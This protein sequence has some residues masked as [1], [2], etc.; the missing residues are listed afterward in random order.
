MAIYR[1]DQ[2]Q[3]TFAA[4]GVAGGAPERLDAATVYTGTALNGAVSKGDRTITV[5]AITNIN[6]TTKQ[7]LIIGGD[8]ATGAINTSELRRVVGITG[9]IVTLENPLSFDH[10]D[11][12]VVEAIDH[13]S[14]NDPDSKFEARTVSASNSETSAYITWIPGIYD[15]VDAPDP[16]EAMEPRYMLGQNTVRNPYQI[17]K[18]Q[19]TLTG[20]VAGITLINGWPLRFALG[21]VQTLQSTGRTKISSNANA[22]LC[23][24]DI[25]K[26][27]VMVKLTATTSATSNGVL[28]AGNYLIFGNAT[29]ATST[30]TCEVRKIVTGT[31]TISAG[32]SAYVR[33]NY[34]VHFAHTAEPAYYATT[35]TSEDA[36]TVFTHHIFDSVE[37]PSVSWNINVKD[38]NGANSFQRRYTGGK[39]GSMTLTAEEGGLLT[40]DWDTATFMNF[41][42][43]QQRS[44]RDGTGA[45]D[46]IRRYLPM[47]DI[48]KADV[49]VPDMAV[50]LPT[51]NPYYFSEGSVKFFNQTVARVR[52]FSLTVANG[53]EARYYIRETYDDSRSPFEIKEGNREY[54]MTATVALPDSA[55][56]TSGTA[57]NLYKEL[58]MA[59]TGAAGVAGAAGNNFAGFDIELK[60]AR[61]GSAND[62]ISIRIPGNYDGSTQAA[63]SGGLNQ[64]ALINSAPVNIDGSNPM[65][66]AVDIVFRDMK[67]EITDNEPHY[68]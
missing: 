40:C 28:A 47:I 41:N 54:S 11:N 46:F 17:V 20:S 39:I 13:S 62:Q 30:T 22:A 66:Q 56:A 61:E 48:G 1:S 27:E 15:T 3:F 45:T 32:S 43:N 68:P 7:F 5:D 14:G 6:L 57:H 64:G 50:Q 29:S 53:E 8:E 9:L 59:G 21:N 38:E 34:P 52:T 55:S 63:A 12:A 10:P 19:Q 33:I 49:G 4:E 2:A 16:V 25:A 44:A 18:G 65:E 51:T 60:F 67:I 31:G 37:L 35:G 42:H 36:A 58:I 23:V 24:T 26:G